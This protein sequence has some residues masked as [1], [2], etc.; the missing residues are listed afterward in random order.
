MSTFGVIVVCP[1][2]ND[3][4]CHDSPVRGRDLALALSLKAKFRD[5]EYEGLKFF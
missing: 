2:S 5:L 1:K 3:K 4:L